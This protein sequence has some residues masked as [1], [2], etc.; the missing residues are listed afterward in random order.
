MSPL[1]RYLLPAFT[2]AVCLA[3]TPQ[4]LFADVQEDAEQILDQAGVTGGFV[5][6]LGAGDGQ[7]TAALR[8]NDSIQVHGLVRDA[9]TIDAIRDRL[10]SAGEYGDVSI[11]RFS[12]KRLWIL[13][14][15]I[16][17]LTNLLFEI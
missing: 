14:M 11:E 6:H 9:D 15:H 4:T 12:G 5:V 17:I 8:K 10:R 2:A 13:F 16:P 3:A 7:L 1:L